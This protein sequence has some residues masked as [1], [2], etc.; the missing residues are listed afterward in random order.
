MPVTLRALLLTATATASITVSHAF[1]F[2]ARGEITRYGSRAEEL[3]PAD[4]DADGDLD[5]VARARLS[6]TVQIFENTGGGRFERGTLWEEPSGGLLRAVAD[7]D[8]DGLPDLLLTGTAAETPVRILYG[9]GLSGYGSR[10]TA[11]GSLPS[12][13]NGL[14]VHDVNNSGK[15]DL[16]LE[17][18]TI[19]DPGTGAPLNVVT[20]DNSAITGLPSRYLQWGDWNGDGLPD[21]FRRI[22]SQLEYVINLGGGQFGASQTRDLPEAL[23]DGSI[24]DD[25]RVIADPRLPGGRAIVAVITDQENDVQR[26]CLLQESG[27]EDTELLFSMNIGGGDDTGGTWFTSFSQE[28]GQPLLAAVG[29][30]K[31]APYYTMGET[32][33][34][35]REITLAFKKG[36]PRLISKTRVK[37]ARIPELLRQTDLDDDGNEDLLVSSIRN[38]DTPSGDLS[39]HRG[40]RKGGFAAKPVEITPPATDDTA[41]H[42]T[43]FD[44]DGDN[45]IIVHG[46]SAADNA[47]EIALL[48]NDGAANFRRRVILDGL[49]YA[50][51]VSIADRNGDGRPDLLVSCYGWRKNGDGERSVILS[52]S[53][54]G[55]ARKTLTLFRE[56]ADSTLDQ[57]KAG[58]WDDDGTD[59]L[60]LWETDYENEAKPHPVRWLKGMANYRFGAPQDLGNGFYETLQDMDRDGDLDLVQSRKGLRRGEPA[61]NGW[62][63]NLGANSLP[64][65]H[66]F[67]ALSGVPETG[68]EI[69]AAEADIDNDGW[70]DLLSFS[71][72]EGARASRGVIVQAGVT[73]T[74][75]APFPAGEPYFYDRYDNVTSRTHVLIA[76][77]P[78]LY[79]GLQGLSFLESTRYFYY[80][81]PVEIAPLSYADW[82]PVLAG[83]LDG[84][85]AM[86]VV[87]SDIQRRPRIEWFKG[88]W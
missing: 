61:Q 69:V 74:P 70:P 33:G 4:L 37:T 43:D 14:H 16:I 9:S 57:V 80:A 46:Y 81:E 17:D 76:T 32:R 35:V 40:N 49:R 56:A 78:N 10:E 68:Y 28:P 73:L 75:I 30:F 72:D 19:L 11:L 6:P 27:P 12:A 24:L 67:P 52:L 5:L 29:G 7:F 39:Y 85:G 45:D 86:D 71:E 60:L 84:D 53:G 15:P 18:R 77:R 2:E 79:S 82:A 62:R 64:L 87:A 55:K 59:D 47:D 41:T 1:E 36:E 83:D 65:F 25:L 22:G 54:K 23:G 38:G 51:L 50:E 44:G 26:L 42:L 20:T 63:E 21:A 13:A 3:L 8:A 88:A 34:E 58:D 48:E 66:A 31:M